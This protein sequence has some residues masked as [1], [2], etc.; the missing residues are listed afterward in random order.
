LIPVGSGPA[1][2]SMIIPEFADGGGWST[3]VILINPT[4]APMNGVVEFYGQGSAAAGGSPLNITVN[5]ETAT[6]FSY[7]IPPFGTT[8]LVTANTS[9]SVQVGSVHLTSGPQNP[10]PRGL[11]IFSHKVL[12]RIVSEAGVPFSA[13]GLAFQTYVEYSETDQIHSGLA[14]A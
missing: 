14:I 5:G 1:G 2:G 12:D 11:A 4:D 13:S 8:R 7:T 3:Q 9:S 6:N 10:V